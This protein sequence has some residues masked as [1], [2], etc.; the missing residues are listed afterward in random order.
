MPDQG[1]P[2][3]EHLEGRVLVAGGEERELPVHR[4]AE[5]PRELVGELHA[6][7]SPGGEDA[8][9]VGVLAVAALDPLDD[10]GRGAEP[11]E[12]VGPDAGEAV[13]EDAEVEREAQVG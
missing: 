2:A 5:E 6:V 4:A 10:L 7:G 11:T 12:V 1:E 13:V 9:G 8:E 3:V